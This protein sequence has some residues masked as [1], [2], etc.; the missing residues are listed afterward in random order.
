M[1]LV[2]VVASIYITTALFDVRGTVDQERIYKTRKQMVYLRIAISDF[3][4][5]NPAYDLDDFDVLVNQ[6]ALFPDCDL[7]YVDTFITMQIP[8]GWC[9]P[10]IDTSLFLGGVDTFKQD[11]WGTEFEISSTSAA[12]IYTYT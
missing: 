6:P 11:A 7:E 3:R 4:T 2:M 12:G 9:G 10:Y 8:T 1:A 5:N